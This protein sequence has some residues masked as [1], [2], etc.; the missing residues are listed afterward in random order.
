M[1]LTTSEQFFIESSSRQ[2][3]NMSE[4]ESKAMLKE[5]I[6]NSVCQQA[7]IRKLVGQIADGDYRSL[8]L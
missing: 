8:F 6:K 5:A 1:E 4:E 2:V 3:D 7:M